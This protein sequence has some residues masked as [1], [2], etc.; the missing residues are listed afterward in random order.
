MNYNFRVLFDLTS[1]INQIVVRKK[2]NDY[3]LYI[4]V[5]TIFFNTSTI[6]TWISLQIND[7][8]K[9]IR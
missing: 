4:N 2:C 9:K 3:V 1:M 6:I 5:S 7:V 8:N